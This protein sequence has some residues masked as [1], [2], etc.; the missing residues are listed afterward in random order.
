MVRRTVGTAVDER[1]RKRLLRWMCNV[2]GH[3]FAWWTFWGIALE[4][5][6]DR[7]VEQSRDCFHACLA[8]KLRGDGCLHASYFAC[9]IIVIVRVAGVVLRERIVWRGGFLHL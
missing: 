4:A 6:A 2:R 8:I 7:V 9:N 1:H 3:F 5:G